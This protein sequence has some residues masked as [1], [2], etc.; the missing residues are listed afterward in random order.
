MKKIKNKVRN[1][2]SKITIIFFFGIVLYISVSFLF[3]FFPFAGTEKYPKPKNIILIVVD[4]LRADRLGFMGYGRNTSPALDSYAQQGII[5]TNFYSQSGWTMPSVASFFTG[6][7]P[8]FHRVEN[9]QDVLSDDEMTLAKMLKSRGYKTVGLC[10]NS[11]ISK[12]AGFAQGFDLWKNIDFDDCIVRRAVSYLDPSM[13]TPEELETENLFDYS[14]FRYMC[15]EKHRAHGIQPGYFD[16]GR[17]GI[18]YEDFEPHSEIRLAESTGEIEPGIYRFGISLMSERTGCA[19][20]VIIRETGNNKK[21]AVLARNRFKTDPEW[22]MFFGELK[23]DRKTKLELIMVPSSTCGSFYVDTP[24]LFPAKMK[25]REGVFLYL[26]LMEVHEP[27][28]ISKYLEKRYLG[29]FN[30]DLL[31]KGDVLYPP[32][33]PYHLSDCRAFFP[34]WKEEHN[35]LNWHSNRYDETIRF[36]DDQVGIIIDSL[37][38]TNEYNDSLVIFTADH[39]QEFFDHGWTG[40]GYSLYNELIHIPMLMIF[41]RLMM[42]GKGK[43]I[44]RNAQTVDLLP[45]LDALTGSGDSSSEDSSTHK[46]GRNLLP[47]MTNSGSDWIESPIFSSDIRNRLN[48]IILYD[49]KYIKKDSACLSAEILFDNIGDY[50]EKNPLNMNKFSIEQFENFRYILEKHSRLVKAY[51]MEKERKTLPPEKLNMDRLAQLGY[52][53]PHYVT[54]VGQDIDCFMAELKLIIIFLHIYGTG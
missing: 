27:N 13:P 52:I 50:N 33:D 40:H 31:N 1:R 10:A 16:R 23:I 38:K 39:G 41:P 21:P 42:D 32:G 18:K 44:H 4:A 7:L 9:Y 46:M 48:S 29:I 53:N 30:D 15:I 8:A 49:R 3:R 5:F 17:Y 47:L 19:V 24:F 36:I 14:G 6:M 20:E 11:I 35:S 26:H 22:K 37:K 25:E 12:E 54:G 28:R 2:N 51:Q 43:E 34:R 45:T